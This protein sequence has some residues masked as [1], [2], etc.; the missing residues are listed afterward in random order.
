MKDWVASVERENQIDIIFA[1]E[2]GSRAWGIAAENSDFDIRFI[3]RYRSLKKY[4]SL[5]KVP[6]AL[7]FQSP[8]DASGFDFFKVLEL[9]AK[10]NPSIYEWAFSPLIYTEDKGFSE[11]LIKV[12]KASYSPF[13][14]Y[15]HYGSLIT[16][17]V[18]EIAKGDFSFRKQKQLIQAIRADLIR[19]EIVRTKKVESP[20]EYVA[21]GGIFHQDMMA[22]YLN[23]T[24]AKKH[25]Y[26]LSF[27][28]VQDLLHLLEASVQETEI[29]DTIPKKQPDI[30][31]LNDWLWEILRLQDY[32]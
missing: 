19:S 27:S 26:L 4:L 12:I 18:K 28:A 8:F 17:N 14:L 21:N 22:A 16:R 1:C 25:Q 23:V 13:S 7:D 29:D 20:F 24:E 3:Y 32:Q 9:I 6:A 5:R 11:S 30:D 15:K 31:A 2:A 10:S